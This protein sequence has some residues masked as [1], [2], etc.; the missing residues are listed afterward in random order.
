MSLYLLRSESLSLPYA[1]VRSQRPAGGRV[2]AMSGLA[3]RCALSHLPVAGVLPLTGGHPSPNT[4]RPA[5]PAYTTMGTVA[6]GGGLAVSTHATTTFSPSRSARSQGE[7]LRP[8][9]VF[10]P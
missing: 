3:V 2:P 7:R 6:C 8:W 1:L 5:M 10:E 9:A 4:V